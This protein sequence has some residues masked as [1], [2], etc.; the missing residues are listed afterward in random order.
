MSPIFD[1][2]HKDCGTFEADAILRVADVGNPEK[3]PKCSVC[4]QPMEKLVGNPGRAIFK[5]KGC[6]A[7]D[8]RSPTRGY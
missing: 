6:H 3:Y 8:Y 1:F 5:G 4:G 7:T 2:E